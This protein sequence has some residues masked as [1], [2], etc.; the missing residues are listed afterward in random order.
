[1]LRDRIALPQCT[2]PGCGEHSL[3]GDVGLLAEPLAFI[4]RTGEC[5]APAAA[6]ERLARL[7]AQK[8]ADEVL[9]KVAKEEQ[10]LREEAVHGKAF[11]D[12][13]AHPG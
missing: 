11:D 4:D 5:Y 12:G 3:P 13:P 6:G 2:A 9:A 7:A 10:Q 8:Y 1:M